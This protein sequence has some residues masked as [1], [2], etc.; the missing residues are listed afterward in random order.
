MRPLAA[1]IIAGLDVTAG[2]RELLLET[3]RGMGS[4]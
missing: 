1:L 3:H 4:A 2:Q